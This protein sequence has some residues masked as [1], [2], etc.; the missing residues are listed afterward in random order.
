MGFTSGAHHNAQNF[1]IGDSDAVGRFILVITASLIMYGR[2]VGLL[3]SHLPF[4]T[5]SPMTCFPEIAAGWGGNPKILME[6]R[7]CVCIH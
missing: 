4:I 5:Y 6:S 3:P 7:L 1:A 2:L